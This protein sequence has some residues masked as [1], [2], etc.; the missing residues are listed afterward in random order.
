MCFAC[1]W[2]NWRSAPEDE[3]WLTRAVI[4]E[5]EARVIGVT[6][7]HG[8]PGGAGLRDHA[9]DGVEFGFT[10][11]EGYR[12]RGYAAEAGE[13]LI[14]WATQE[15][16]V[17]SY[18]LSVGPTND[19][20]ARSRPEARLPAGWGVGASAAWTR[21]RVPAH[22]AH[23]SRSISGGGGDDD[24]FGGAASGAVKDRFDVV[25]VGIEDERRVVTRVVGALTRLA[26]VAGRQRAALRRGN[27]P[28]SARSAA[29]KAR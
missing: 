7:F 3:P 10:I 9:P 5:A 1:V 22:D 4:L 19:A 17:R 28:P 2:A 6:G 15:H 12:R 24:G 16:G 26:V 8:R 14:R 18:L 23:G 20:S 27:D 21:A 13:A 11:F 25:A 29:W